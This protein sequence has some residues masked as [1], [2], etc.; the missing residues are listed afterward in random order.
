LRVL[1]VVAGIVLV[2]LVATIALIHTQTAKRLALERI[3][4]YL[5]SQD[6]AMEADDFEYSFIPLHISA[7]R[8]A[9]YKISSPDLSRFFQADH[10]SVNVRLKDLLRRRYRVE[11]LQVENPAVNVVIDE[12]HRDNIPGAS[13]K[14]SASSQPIDLLILK[15]RSTGGSFKMEDRSKNLLPVF[16]Y[17][18]CPWMPAN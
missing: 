14:S 9:V 16:R 3:Q 2:L 15:L 12:Q 6:V 10:F 1:V 5:K 4:K 13:G 7:S 11:D 8:I 17:G 18:I